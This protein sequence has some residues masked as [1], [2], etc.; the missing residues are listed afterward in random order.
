MMNSAP[1]RLDVYQTSIAMRTFEHATATRQ[2]AEAVVV[3]LE[4][5]DGSVGWGETLPREYVTGETLESVAED[6]E[7]LYW[8]IR[9]DA[10]AQADW[11][12]DSSA[13]SADGESLAAR[14]AVELAWQDALARSAGNSL[15]GPLPPGLRVSGV[16]GSSNPSQT[17]RRLRLMRWFGLRDF[18]LKLGLGEQ[19]DAENL[20]LTLGIIGKAVAAGK[21]TLRVDVNGGWTAEETPQRVAYLKSQG[22][23]AVEQPVRGCAE[24]LIGLAGRCELPLIADESMVTIADA[25]KLIGSAAGKVWLNIRLSKNGGLTLCRRIARRAAAARVPF[26]IGCM[27]GETS[28]LSAAQRA[29]LAGCPPAQAVEGNYGKFLL[30]DDLSVRSIRFSYGGRLRALKGPGLGIRVD[31]GRVAQ[32]GKL[33]KTLRA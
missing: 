31:P 4:L 27:V 12:S 30:G 21:C 1:V 10:G 9:W 5:A 32:Y 11:R 14:C 29:L 15:A 6:I 28:I 23:S 26:V 18:K 19:V 33:I 25:E 22:V 7:R 20:R 17:T 13:A 2:V 24:A 3:R 8:P 16:L